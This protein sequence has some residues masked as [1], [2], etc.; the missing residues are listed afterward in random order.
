MCDFLGVRFGSDMGYFCC[1]FVCIQEEIENVLLNIV[2]FLFCQRCFRVFVVRINRYVFRV[3]SK[4]KVNQLFFFDFGF[5]Y[6]R[7]SFWREFIGLVWIGV[8]CLVLGDLG[9]LVVSVVGYGDE[10]F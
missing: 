4:K 3:Y 1:Y 6:L 2:Q 8:Y 9:R 5:F 7:I 10:F